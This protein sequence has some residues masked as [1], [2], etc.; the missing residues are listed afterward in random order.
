MAKELKDRCIVESRGG[1][2]G[3]KYLKYDCG[4]SITRR[5][6]VI[7]ITDEETG[8][9]RYEFYDKDFECFY[10]HRVLR[11]LFECKLFSVEQKRWFVEELNNI[12]VE[13]PGF[14]FDYQGEMLRLAIA[15]IFGKKI[16]AGTISKEDLQLYKYCKTLL[17]LNRRYF[18]TDIERQIQDRLIAT[19]AE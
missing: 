19:T 18:E 13:I 8:I 11:G 7:Y 3:F 6:G 14:T 15:R 4:Y 17:S 12:E 16:N 10:L 5:N 2:S 1:Y 9:N